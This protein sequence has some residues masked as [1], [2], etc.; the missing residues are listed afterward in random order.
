[1]DI[2]TVLAA[3]D[4]SRREE[5]TFQVP[6]K[7]WEHMINFL[8]HVTRLNDTRFV[9]QRRGGSIGFNVTEPNGISVDRTE[10]DEEMVCALLMRLRPFVLR[11]DYYYLNQFIGGTLKRYLKHAVFHNVLNS[12]AYGFSL[13]R[14]D[15]AK[16]YS[17]AR[18]PLSFNAVMDWLNAFEYH[19]D[20]EKRERVA[21][22]LGPFS[23]VQNGLN[24]VLFAL[25]D[26]VEA[27]RT[28]GSVVENIQACAD[29]RLAEILCEPKLFHR[30]PTKGGK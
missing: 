6:E 2:R 29:G 19:F 23:T 14:F 3:S 13:K 11:K 4:G 12:A 21:L 30:P 26:I 24:V 9:K 20:I 5:V 1:M 16:L 22:D 18:A 15:N 28:A 27:V 25:V 10:V 7:D 17:S 8:G